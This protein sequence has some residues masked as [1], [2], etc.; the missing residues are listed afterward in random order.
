[1]TDDI[2][3][4]WIEYTNDEGKIV[5]ETLRPGSQVKI[6]RADNK[7]HIKLEFE[8]DVLQRVAVYRNKDAGSHPHVKLDFEGDALQGAVVYRNK[9]AD[10]H[11]HAQLDFESDALQ[12]AIVYR[13]KENMDA[14]ILYR[15]NTIDVTVSK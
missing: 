13:D 12:R 6:I 5:K 14:E 7:P 8:D 3:R 15:N 4:R 10:N 11:I 1:M 9:E 2:G